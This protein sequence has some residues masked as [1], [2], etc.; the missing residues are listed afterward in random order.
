MPLFKKKDNVLSLI[1]AVQARSEKELQRLVEANLKDVLD[2]HFLAS[3]F[4]T[5]NGRIDTLAI[6]SQG[7]PVVIEYKRNQNHNVINQSL[8]YLKWLG[9]LIRVARKLPIFPTFKAH[10]HKQPARRQ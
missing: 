2:M 4:M 1:N 9:K 7:A 6:D 5:S 10:R 8:S 3:E